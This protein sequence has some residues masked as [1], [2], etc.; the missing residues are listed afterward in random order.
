MRTPSPRKALVFLSLAALAAVLAGELLLRVF[1]YEQLK[2]QT[3]P[4]IYQRDGRLGYRYRPGAESTID[5]PS[6]S[7]D[8]RINANG[9]YG[10]PFVRAKRPGCFRIA[11]VG[12][13]VAT[14]LWLQGDR[15]FSI[16]LQDELDSRGWNVEVLNFSIDGT[17]RDIPM[18]RQVEGEVLQ[19][20]V[21]LVLLF[22]AVPISVDFYAR[23]TYQGYVYSPGHTGMTARAAMEERAR[24]RK[25]IDQVRNSSFTMLYDASFL[26]RAFL[27]SREGEPSQDLALPLPAK[28]NLYRR[29]R[30]STAYRLRTLPA[31]HSVA[32]IAETS[33]KVRE[34]GAEMI[35]VQ[36]GS[37]FLQEEHFDA[38]GIEFH[39]LDIPT[40]PSLQHEHD[41][42]YNE[43][44]HALI[45]ERLLRFVQPRIPAS[46]RMKGGR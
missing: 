1:Y 5:V 39:A 35:V 40:D 16:W 20:S 13:S 8:V 33:Q 25:L 18:L 7:K 17:Q 12:A 21:D 3:R 36:Y 4:I 32:R 46:A 2:I 31:E 23:E 19:H 44:G 27:R 29:K 42:H 6:I 45:G 43:L 37:G 10:R 14:G 28:M 38:A 11:V 41:P 30:L 26:V 9:Y 22:M 34:A 24:M 15:S